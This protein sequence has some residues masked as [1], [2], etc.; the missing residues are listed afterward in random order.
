MNSEAS[1]TPRAKGPWLSRLAVNLLTFV[2]GILIYWL[3][4]FVVN[5]IGSVKGPSLDEVEK[6]HLS[7]VL[8]ERDKS[9]TR[10]IT[11][12]KR[13]VEKQ[14]QKQKLLSQS[15]QG[16]QTTMGQL[17]ELQKL[18]LEKNLALSTEQSESFNDSLEVF[19]SNQERF[20]TINEEIA[21]L[22]ETQ[23]TLEDEQ[24]EVQRKL[25]T[26]RKPAREEY[27]HLLESHRLVE[28]QKV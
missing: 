5:D 13:L 1:K 26:Q 9:L 10:E 17:L 8:V 4:G 25:E 15:S 27:T 20:Q 6:G 19:L 21:S 28:S 18:S 23:Q 3:L 16:L 14:N 22:V 2:V 24:A 12:T 11:Q 7:A